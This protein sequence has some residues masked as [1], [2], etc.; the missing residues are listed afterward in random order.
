[1]VW[2][3]RKNRKNLKRHGLQFKAHRSKEII[4][5]QLHNELHFTCN[6]HKSTCL[7]RSLKLKAV[8]V[9]IFVFGANCY[10]HVCHCHV[11]NALYQI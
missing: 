7:S 11:E 4:H 3:V 9:Y 10:L 1:M 5:I 8:F 2:Q 6:V